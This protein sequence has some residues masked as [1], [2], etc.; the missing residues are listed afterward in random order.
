MIALCP[1]YA[2]RANHSTI[3]IGAVL[4]TLAIITAG[5]T[6]QEGQET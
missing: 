4:L 5:V 1:V 3:A 6:P 2:P